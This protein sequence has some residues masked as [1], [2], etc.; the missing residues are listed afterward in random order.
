MGTC[1]VLT[2]SCRPFQTT[3]DVA[4]ISS[5]AVF[6]E[7]PANLAMYYWHNV[8]NAN[9]IIS[10]CRGSHGV[11]SREGAQLLVGQKDRK[12]CQPIPLRRVDVLV[13]HLLL[14]SVPVIRHVVLCN[15]N[16]WLGYS[17]EE[18]RYTGETLVVLRFFFPWGLS[19]TDAPLNWST[20]CVVSPLRRKTV[21]QNAT[22]HRFTIVSGCGCN[23]KIQFRNPDSPV[24]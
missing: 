8:V 20:Q 7:W 4:L 15:E 14:I 24:S 23:Q 22:W 18:F 10:I 6:T 1:S 13:F 2:K 5:L 16:L 19:R 12:W 11:G 3:V 9:T 17:F 21:A